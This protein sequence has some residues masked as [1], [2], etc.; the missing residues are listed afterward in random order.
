MENNTKHLSF[1]FDGKGINNANDPYRERLAT[2]SPQ[3]QA[4][5]IGNLIASAPELLRA[6]KQALGLLKDLNAPATDGVR[7]LLTNAIAKAEGR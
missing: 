7:G 3:G 4:L 2:L 6:C 1:T 5:E